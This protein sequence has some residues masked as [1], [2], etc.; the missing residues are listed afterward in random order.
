[1]RCGT[2]AVTGSPSRPSSRGTED[3]RVRAAGSHRRARRATAGGLL[4]R[5]AGGVRRGVPPPARRRAALGTGDLIEARGQGGR[6][7]IA[8]TGVGSPPTG[9]GRRRLRPHG[10]AASIRQPATATRWPGASRIPSSSRIGRSVH[11]SAN[12]AHHWGPRRCTSAPGRTCAD[13]ERPHP[14]LDPAVAVR[15]EGVPAGE[16]AA[17][18][19][20]GPTAA[21]RAPRRQDRPPETR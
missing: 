11:S 5:G 13:G 3:Q 4:R 19:Q 8:G 6:R 7:V 17:T 10:I 2:G 20:H 14:A 12:S 21:G 16:V 9:D 15:W 1:M 18:D